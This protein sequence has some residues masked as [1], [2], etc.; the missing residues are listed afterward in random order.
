[1][2]RKPDNSIAVTTAVLNGRA[3]ILRR[4]TGDQKRRK[5]TLACAEE[6]VVF[7]ALRWQVYLH[8]VKLELASYLDTACQIA[9]ILKKEHWL[10]RL[11][12]GC[13]RFRELQGKFRK[14][15]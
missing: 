5:T 12:T 2:K 11:N 6:L 15:T 13:G 8:E 10:P 1:M 4:L 3:L 14:P 9:C 7:L